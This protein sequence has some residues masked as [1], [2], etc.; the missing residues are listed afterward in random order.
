MALAT[1]VA[2]AVLGTHGVQYSPPQPTQGIAA[3]GA[4]DGSSTPTPWQSGTPVAQPDSGTSAPINFQFLLLGFLALV[5]V[6]LL[7]LLIV[8]LT[9]WLNARRR[10]GGSGDGAVDGGMAE[11]DGTGKAL[12]GAVLAGRE[13]LA[14]DPDARTAII[15]CYAAMEKSLAESGISRRKADTPTDLLQRAADAGLVQGIAAQTLTDLFSEARYSTHPMGEH[16]RDQARAALQSISAHLAAA[17]AAA[18][19]DAR[20]GAREE[21]EI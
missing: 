8:L 17:A 7:V 1:A 6:A 12:A 9:R 16:Q 21:I 3:Q 10:A 4:N 15:A 18:A 14:D 5:G 13:A 20:F 2:L 11:G 19:A